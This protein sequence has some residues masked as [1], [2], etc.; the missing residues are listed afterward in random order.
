MTTRSEL[1]RLRAIVERLT[2]PRAPVV[3]RDGLLAKMHGLVAPYVARDDADGLAA[4]GL[5]MVARGV[6]PALLFMLLVRLAVDAGAPDSFLERLAIGLEPLGVTVEQ[7]EA[8]H[9]ELTGRRAAPEGA[10]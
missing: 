10:S 7:I 9:A 3:S 8:A 6:R 4:Y 2:V 1:A 5:R